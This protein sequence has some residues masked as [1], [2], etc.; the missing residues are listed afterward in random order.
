MPVQL[1]PSQQKALTLLDGLADNLAD[2]LSYIRNLENAK[3][4]AGDLADASQLDDCAFRVTNLLVQIQGKALNIID[5]SPQL[6]Q[7]I[8][9]L[10]TAI[11]QIKDAIAV[12]QQADQAVAAIGAIIQVASGAI[13]LALTV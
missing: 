1:S 2:F 8:Q 10:G 12:G 13:S 11:K 6:T 3:T 7:A 5:D 9:Q 4:A